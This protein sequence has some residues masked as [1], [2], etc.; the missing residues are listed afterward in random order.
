MNPDKSGAAVLSDRDGVRVSRSGTTVHVELVSPER[1]NAMTPATWRRLAGIPQE[2]DDTDRAVILT[3]EGAGFCAGLD[4]RMFSP[5]GIPG[6]ESLLELVRGSD[7][8]IDDF[9]T[10]AQKAF[11]WWRHVPQL[12]IAY[13]HG[14]AIGAGFQLALSCD[15]ILVDDGA[16]FAMREASLGLIPDLAGTAPL[17]AAVG[18]SRALEICATGRAVDAHEAVALGIALEVVPAVRRDERLSELLGALLSPAADVVAEL[19]WLLGG[20]SDGTDQLVREREAQ[21]RRLRALSRAVSG[22]GST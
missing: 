22:G 10:A 7:A 4:R 11:T 16:S 15:V 6:E 18:Y 20:I 5:D 8:E 3:G 13:V 14:H 19:K 21:L 2:L 9:I 1:R 12:T 17:V